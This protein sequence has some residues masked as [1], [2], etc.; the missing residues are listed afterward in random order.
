M[1]I[2][3]NKTAYKGKHLKVIEKKFLTKNGKIGTWECIE[4]EGGVLI[5]ALT[6]NKKVILEK[7]FRI[8]INSYSIELPAGATDKRNESL[9]ETARRELKEE[10]GYLAKKMIKIFSWQLSPWVALSKGTL[11][12]AP[13]VEYAGKSD[14]EDEEE[15]IILEKP[16][17][18]L[19]KVLIKESKKTP[20]EISI[21]GAIALLKNKKML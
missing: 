9:E 5:F 18:D 21:W 17:K 19:E 2:I 10:T 6:K 3:K 14:R 7:I 20:V 1:K 13:D 4:R 16:L 15:I 8:P 11:F 12:F